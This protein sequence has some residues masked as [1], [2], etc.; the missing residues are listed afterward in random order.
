MNRRRLILAGGTVAFAAIGAARRNRRPAR[1]PPFAHSRCAPVAAIPLAGLVMFPM[2]SWSPGS[3]ASAFLG[4]AGIF[5]DPIKD[6]VFRVAEWVAERIVDII[7]A[8]EWAWDQSWEVLT[9]SFDIMVEQYHNVNNAVG[10]VIA[11]TRDMLDGAFSNLRQQLVS[12]FEN[13]WDPIRDWVTDNIPDWIGDALGGAW[14]LIESLSNLGG[15]A[16]SDLIDFLNDPIGWIW[17]LISDLVNDA[18][19]VGVDAAGIGW[20]VFWGLFWPLLAQQLGLPNDPKDMIDAAKLLWTVALAWIS[21][22]FE[23]GMATLLDGAGDYFA[24]K[25]P[26]EVHKHSDLLVSLIYEAM[27]IDYPKSEFKGLLDGV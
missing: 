14:G 5:I 6:F 7:N 19:Q 27:G 21:G 23:R 1:N 26:E 15:E 3:V 4:W 18:I 9:A 12:Y 8:V 13:A 2:A 10:G 20:D 24:T 17:N 25:I 11:D 16:V 22:D